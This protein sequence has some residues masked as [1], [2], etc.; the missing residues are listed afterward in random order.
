VFVVTGGGRGLGKSLALALVA[1][2]KSVLI[3]GRQASALVA[4]ANT[5][6][7]ID[8]C[9]ADVST[10]AG[11]E[12]VCDKL[13]EVKIIEG[14]IHNAGM[15]DPI[16]PLMSIDE[17]AW[18]K[19]MAINVEA[20]LFLSQKLAPQLP[21]GRV[22]NISS[23]AAHFPVV[24]WSAYCVSK[25]ALS[26]LTRCWQLECTS[27]AFASVMPGIIDTDMAML[28]RQ[29]EHMDPEKLNFFKQLKQN[30]RLLS[31]DTVALFLCW[32]LLDIKPSEYVAKEWDIY[33]AAH[34]ASWL[35]TN[36]TAPSLE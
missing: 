35:P 27:P 18:K 13:K 1:R 4:V 30:N 34:H 24:G 28:I 21:N 5:S 29:S 7:S 10:H 8:Y 11:R 32:L 36:H 17:M 15:I 2:G 6:D 14:L 20:P 3:I 19:L 33:D 31:P 23:G 12:L 16:M 25:A 9:V 26:M 22:L